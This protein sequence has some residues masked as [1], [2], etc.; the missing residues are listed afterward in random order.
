MIGRHDSSGNTELRR[1]VAMAFLNKGTALAVLN[2][3]DD[4]VEAFD[5]VVQRYGANEPLPSS[6]QWRRLL[7]TRREYCSQRPAGRKQYTLAMR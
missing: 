5:V 7:S 4:A 6:S 3:V 1:L 2:R